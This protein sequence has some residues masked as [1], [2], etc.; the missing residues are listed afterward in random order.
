[1]SVEE[2]ET[3]LRSHGYVLM[4]VV[5]AN[6]EIRRAHIEGDK[7]GSKNGWYRLNQK[8]NRLW[9]VFGSHK[10]GERTVW[11]GWDRFADRQVRPRPTIPVAQPT[12]DLATLERRWELAAPADPLHP[13]LLRKGVEAFGIRQHAGKLLIPVR[14]VD[15]TFRGLQRIHADGEKRFY[16]GTQKRAG[17]HVIGEVSDVILIA[18]GY[19]TAASCFIATGRCSVVAFDA[20]NLLHVGEA[21]RAAY[22]HAGLFFMADADPDGGVGIPA[23]TK[24]ADAVEGTVLNPLTLLKGEA[25]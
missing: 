22:P 11:K 2:F 19:A 20:S 14:F 10:T 9:G 7:R 23:A 25:A 3:E 17:M 4:D 13:Y 6:S 8:G 18:E 24:A 12:V 15:G 21:I 5:R 1:M 16:S